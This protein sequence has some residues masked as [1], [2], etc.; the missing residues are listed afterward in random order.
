[1]P[2]STHSTSLPRKPEPEVGRL[3][4]PNRPDSSV[5]AG[6]VFA[7]GLLMTAV[8]APVIRTVPTA[9]P[10]ASPRSTRIIP[11]ILVGF[12]VAYLTMPFAEPSGGRGPW[13]LTRAVVVVVVALIAAKPWIELRVGVLALA[14]TVALAALAVCVV[15]PPGFFG[16]TRAA[17]YG[18]AAATFVAV[19]SYARSLRRAY[20]IAAIVALAGAVQFYWS[21]LAWWGG[22]QQSVPMVGTFYWH[23][24]FGA[25]LLAPA[26]LGLALIVRHRTPWCWAGWVVAPLSIAGIVYSSSRGAMVLAVGGWLVI[27][28]LAIRVRPNR[29]SVLRWLAASAIAVGV[30]VAVAGP[31]FFAS[32]ASPLSAVQARAVSG[33]TAEVNADYRLHMWRES[34]TVFEHNPLAGVGYGALAP[35]A[36]KLTPAS[37]PRSPLAHN[38]YL[39]SLAEGGLL[40]G[41]PFLIACV[42]IGIGL[43]RVVRSKSRRRVVDVRTG[44]AVAAA[45]LMVHAAIDFDWSYPALFT[46]AAV[47]AAVATAPVLRRPDPIGREMQ[48]PASIVGGRRSTRL[49]VACL[50]LLAGGAVVGG[51]V[52]HRGAVR[53]E[54]LH[55]T[56]PTAGSTASG[57][58]TR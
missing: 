30:T 56:Q 25:F 53:L 49:R 58:V 44:A 37:W 38:D 26:L 8:A 17:A 51:I 13:A 22:R 34:L 45:A 20:V 43:V 47:V 32:D 27:G 57:V 23:N 1:M 9:P 11:G 6:H 15:T 52:G 4:R 41:L 10:V 18:L 35:A 24:Q 40:L 3:A 14:A 21:F 2:S 28:V 12:A 36:E 42:G 48:T 31:P 55:A 19:A 5:K 7:D 29:R 46:L 16:A 54:W 39:Q 33:E 50:T